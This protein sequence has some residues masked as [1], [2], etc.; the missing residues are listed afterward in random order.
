MNQIVAVGVVSKHGAEIFAAAQGGREYLKF[1]LTDEIK[2]FGAG[3]PRMEYFKVLSGDKDIRDLHAR[4]SPGT[5]V[6]VT[7]SASLDM[8][9]DKPDGTRGFVTMKIYG[10]VTILSEAPRPQSRIHPEDVPAQARP[11]SDNDGGGDDDVPY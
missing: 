9:K 11:Q 1:T 2:A 6:M 8:P 7:G 10:T 3:K 5:K 4:L